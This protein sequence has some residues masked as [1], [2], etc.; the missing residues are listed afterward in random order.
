MPIIDDRTKG[1][2]QRPKPYW[3][4]VLV[5]VGFVVLWL[6]FTTLFSLLPQLQ[7]AQSRAAAVS[8]VQPQFRR[9]LLLQAQ[10][11]LSAGDVGTASRLIDDVS[12]AGA[13]DVMDKHAYFR[14]A[15][16]VKRKQGDPVASASFYERFLSMGAG[17]SKPECQ[18]CHSA[19][20]IPPARPS[21]LETSS[22]GTEYVS[23]LRAAGKLKAAR[24]RLLGE[25]KTQPKNL[26]AH[27][28][29]FHV[30]KALRHPAAA[31]EHAEVLK[32][33]ASGG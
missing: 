33:D 12:T 9:N 1:T 13:L 20:T 2:D 26:R 7:S 15:A 18:S 17:V 29:L 5:L 16:R 28:L 32:D 27:L 19:G 30:E 22:L 11:A 24:Q 3:P 31:V 6:G 21:D 14:L 25:L 4:W 10:S 8:N 23:A